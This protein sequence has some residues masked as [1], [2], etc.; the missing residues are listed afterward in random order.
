MKYL[1]WLLIVLAGI[2]WIRKQRQPKA[3]NPSN[4]DATPAQ[5]TAMLPCAHCGVLSPE[6]EM[7]Q[8]KQGR[9]CSEAHRQ[10][11]EG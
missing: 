4:A 6:N 1:F 7:V 10:S 8:G 11:H 3:P 9:Y 2:W 5:P